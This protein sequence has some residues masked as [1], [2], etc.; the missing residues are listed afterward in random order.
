MTA[1]T[2]E[3]DAFEVGEEMMAV[4]VL[5]RYE[6]GESVLF[7]H[8]DSIPDFKLTIQELS[9]LFYKICCRAYFSQH[10]HF[11]YA[12]ASPFKVP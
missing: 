12:Q 3:N 5:D 1:A 6:R 9:A 7:R 2:S 10:Y 4:T 8:V 11:K